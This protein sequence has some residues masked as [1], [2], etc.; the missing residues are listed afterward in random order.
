MSSFLFLPLLSLTVVYLPIKDEIRLRK[1]EEL[2][3]KKVLIVIFLSEP[4]FLPDHEPVVTQRFNFRRV[5]V[6]E[7][8]RRSFWRRFIEN[9][10]VVDNVVIVFV[11]TQI[12][13]FAARVFLNLLVNIVVI[14]FLDKFVG[15]RTEM[16]NAILNCN[17]ILS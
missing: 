4:D 17:S 8:R 1:N 7:R 12:T 13:I 11:E 2:P 9:V 14:V 6:S 3:F 15:M 5:K 10:V 16:R